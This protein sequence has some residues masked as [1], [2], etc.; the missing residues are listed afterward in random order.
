MAS[1]IILIQLLHQWFLCALKQKY[2]T[3]TYINVADKYQC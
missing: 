2:V 3:V 1:Q